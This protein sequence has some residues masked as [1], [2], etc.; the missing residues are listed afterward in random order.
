ME[1]PTKAVQ[2]IHAKTHFGFWVYLMTDAI[3]FSILFATY[4]VLHTNTFGGPSEKIC[5]PFPTTS[6]KL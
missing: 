4:A 5:S 3:L 6:T 1:L 2:E